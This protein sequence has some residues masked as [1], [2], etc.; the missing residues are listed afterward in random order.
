MKSMRLPGAEAE[1][2]VLPKPKCHLQEFLHNYPTKRLSIVSTRKLQTESQVSPV[3]V[4]T[5]SSGAPAELNC[6]SKI[7][8]LKPICMMQEFLHSFPANAEKISTKTEMKSTTPV[9][10][11]AYVAQPL[12]L[13]RTPTKRTSE[14][15]VPRA[16]QD[17]ASIFKTYNYE[18]G[19]VS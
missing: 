13:A 18:D 6:P 5:T 14:E 12:T 1:P 15:E 8:L 9:A 4:A 3:K 10:T 2:T 19:L 16:S 7:T 11:Y 17:L